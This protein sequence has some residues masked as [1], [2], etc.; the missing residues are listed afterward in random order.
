LSS[1]QTKC[2]NLTN[3][4]RCEN[5]FN[6]FNENSGFISSENFNSYN[7]NNKNIYKNDR[8]SSRKSK[9]V[10]L[11]KNIKNNGKKI[12]RNKDSNRRKIGNQMLYDEINLLINHLLLAWRNKI[13]IHENNYDEKEKS[14]SLYRLVIVQVIKN[15]KKYECDH[16]N[17]IK[18]LFYI[19]NKLSI[20]IN[21]DFIKI[22]TNNK[23]HNIK[24][25]LLS[26]FPEY[27]EIIEKV[28]REAVKVNES[29]QFNIIDVKNKEDYNDFCLFSENINKF[30]EK[31]IL[32]D[33]NKKGNNDFCLF[34]ENISKFQE[35]DISKESNKK[36]KVRNFKVYNNFY[37]FSD[38]K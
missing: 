2:T 27:I 36:G 29:N 6:K 33:S 26:W 7:N 10:K 16:Y 11:S 14:Y 17:Y 24:Q 4:L 37:S 31:D 8:C 19:I 32:E 35:K 28:E 23:C 20:F 18:Y 30:Q 25:I 9:I 3:N 38:S 21:Q 15:L 22:Y 5:R 34:S 1:P 12:E 13:V